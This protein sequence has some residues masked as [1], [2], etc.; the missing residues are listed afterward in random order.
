MTPIFI[1]HP[2]LFH[3]ITPPPQAGN[4]LLFVVRDAIV[5]SVCLSN[6][7]GQAVVLRNE[8]EQMIES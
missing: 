6:G 5:T 4:G 3:P 8:A 1:P 2:S 7:R